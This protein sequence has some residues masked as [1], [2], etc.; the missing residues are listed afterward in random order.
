MILDNGMIR[1]E[2]YDWRKYKHAVHI[3]QDQHDAL[4]KRLAENGWTEVDNRFVMDAHEEW[5]K[6][7]YSAT[8]PGCW[9]RTVEG[10]NTIHFELSIQF[11]TGHTDYTREEWDAKWKKRKEAGYVVVDTYEIV[12]NPTVR[13]CDIKYKPYRPLDRVAERMKEAIDINAAHERLINWKNLD[14]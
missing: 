12:Q 5:I 8:F 11:K 6:G 7:K 1:D 3:P 13:L 2:H 14:K 10:H 9:T 4:R